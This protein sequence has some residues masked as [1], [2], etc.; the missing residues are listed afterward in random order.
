MGAA[1][2]VRPERLVP[3][4]ACLDPLGATVQGDVV[5]Q[6]GEVPLEGDDADARLVR[7]RDEL[8]ELL[9]MLDEV[10]VPG[11]AREKMWSRSWRSS[12]LSAYTT[13]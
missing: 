10:V 9:A 11:R 2:C 3:V 1:Q 5:G 4:A 13:S 7:G 12:H 6:R 8:D